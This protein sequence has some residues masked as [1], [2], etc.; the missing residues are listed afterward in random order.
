MNMKL[1]STWCLGVLAGV[2]AFAA[3]LGTAPSALADD[4]CGTKENPCP[5]QKWMRANMG[6]AA[7]A[8]DTAALA[9][10][11][12]KAATFSPD[13][14]WTWAKIANDG[15]AAAKKGDLAG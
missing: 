6:T 9:K 4:A 8:E 13:A 5:L 2:L 11:L 12:G 10:A 7:A 1:K 14:G 15:A 3:V